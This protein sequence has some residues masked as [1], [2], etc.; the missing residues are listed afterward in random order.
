MQK[1]LHGRAITYGPSRLKALDKFLR[2]TFLISLSGDPRVLLDGE[3]FWEG[4]YAYF[5]VESLHFAFTEKTNTLLSAEQTGRALTR[6][7]VR[8]VQRRFEEGKRIRVRMVPIP[9]G[10]E[11]GTP[12]QVMADYWNQRGDNWVGS[13][14]GQAY[15]TFKQQFELHGVTRAATPICAGCI[16]R[17][18]R[19]QRRSIV[20]SVGQL[21]RR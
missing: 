1:D 20:G 9:E 10:A 11:S 4:R 8:S 21:G 16:C 15:I 6:L 18:S 19:G 5:D 14:T 2:E 3:P 12:P 13:T 7:G 17:I